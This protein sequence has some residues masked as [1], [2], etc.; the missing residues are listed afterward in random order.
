MKSRK[1]DSMEGAR[2]PASARDGV[3]LNSIVGGVL[4]FLSV[5]LIP[6]ESEGSTSRRYQLSGVHTA[7]SER[8]LIQG[9]EAINNSRIDAAIDNFRLLTELNP[10]F[11]LAQLILGDL[12]SAQAGSLSGFG[13]NHAVDHRKLVRE[14]RAEAQARIRHYKNHP[15]IGHVPLPLLHLS[16]RQDHAIVVD[17]SKSRLYLF[18]NWRGI[19]KLI[20]DYYISIG[21]RGTKKLKRGDKKTPIGLYYIVDT[22]SSEQLPPL[23]GAGALPLDYPN[24]WDKFRKR[25]GYGIWLHGTDPE[26]Y[27][28]PPRDS[29]GCVALTNPDFR[30]IELLA[31]LGTPVLMQENIPWVSFNRWRQEREQ[32][33]KQMNRWRRDWSSGDIS[34]LITHYSGQFDTGKHDIH[35]WR[36]VLERSLRNERS[37]GKRVQI[38]D[39]NIFHY[40]DDLGP[41]L[42]VRFRRNAT[43]HIQFWRYQQNRWAI[44][45]EEMK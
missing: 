19:P 20:A 44:I 5:A 17:L 12:L 42:M 33:L 32:F 30:S 18:R 35:G 39:L 14:L 11:R 2:A 41:M 13:G 10:D 40:P 7:R 23:Y 1:V 38:S 36:K 27:S 4:L 43:R 29:N 31:G 22:V 45:Y 34:R 3:W 6:L 16:D 9:M 37:R 28:R 25:T 26:T 24:A 15:P 8:L 21:K